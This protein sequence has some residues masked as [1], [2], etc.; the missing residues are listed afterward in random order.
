MEKIKK[1]KKAKKYLQ[2]LIP[3]SAKSLFLIAAYIQI[4][5]SEN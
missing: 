3:E 2:A 1:S 5:Y 4:D